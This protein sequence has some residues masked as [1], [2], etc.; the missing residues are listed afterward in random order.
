MAL[1]I[2]HCLVGCC[3]VALLEKNPDCQLDKKDSFGNFEDF[4][5]NGVSLHHIVAKAPELHRGTMS[6]P[7]FLP[8][9]IVVHETPFLAKCGKK[10]YDFGVKNMY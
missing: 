9:F 6:K 4:I 8:G 7:G 1:Y 3:L 10:M 5:I 2:F